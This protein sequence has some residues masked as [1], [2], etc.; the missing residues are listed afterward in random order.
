MGGAIGIPATLWI[1]GATA[2]IGMAEYTVGDVIHNTISPIIDINAIII[3]GS[4]LL[5]GVGLII[6]GARRCLNNQRALFT[7]PHNKEG[8]VH[9]FDLSSK[10]VATT[11]D[12]LHKF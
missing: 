2:V 8:V 9:L 1:G 6:D 5:I 10:R 12:E 11:F 3:N 4:I 7:L